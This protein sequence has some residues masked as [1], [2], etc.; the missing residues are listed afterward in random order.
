MKIEVVMPKMGESLQEGTITKWLKKEGEIVERDE[1]ILEIST[2]KV[3]TE[4]PSPNAGVL[5]KILVQE[6]ETVEVGTPIAIIETD[7]SAVAETNSEP[8]KP[9]EVKA[10]E[11]TPQPTPEVVPEAPQTAPASGNT[12]DVVMPK[13]GESLQEGTVIKWLKKVGEVV[14]RDEMILEISTDKVDTEVPSPVSGTIV[15]ILANE[16]DTVE[17][18]VVIARIS[19]GASSV[20]TPSTKEEAPKAETKPEPSP[21]AK[22]SAPEVVIPVSGGTTEI[23]SR[24]GD[25]FYSPLVRAMAKDSGV[26]LE[27]LQQIQGTGIQGRVTK[28][29][30]NKYIANRGTAKS[31]ATPATAQAS[32]TVKPATS[33]ASV[34]AAPKAPVIN[35][36][37]GDDVEIIPMDRIRQLI[38]DHMVY[39]KHTSAHVTSVAEVD[40]TNLVNFRNKYKDKFE[41][42]E[43]FK[44]TYTPF[45]VQA[46][47]D[48]IR[49]FPM[50]NVSVDGKNIIR[51]KRINLGVATA[52]PDGNLIVP[53]IKNA[54]VLNI[55]GLARSVYDLATRARNKKLVPDEIQGG[56][57][58]LTNVGTFGTL[59][60]TPVINQ[61]QCGIF[62]V[63]AIKKRAVVKEVEGND[64]ILVRH[65]MY[66]SITYDH[67]VIDGML[68]GQ[69]LAAFVKALENMNENTITL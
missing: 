10:P 30:L 49:Q 34:P 9:Q 13:M 33:T 47:V 1:M 55:T 50:V 63:G 21:S 22:T 27:E 35:L 20:A 14:E 4:V 24:M 65:M 29:D 57:F 62:G 41:K 38:S 39:S 60:G 19:T 46:A 56:T 6:Q 66:C 53:V 43:G 28:E 11:P 32:A 67:R 45:F 31:Q 42:Q 58:T 25:N 16:G 59:F 12:I 8:P 44:L 36:P 2:D 37:S 61:P 26:T 17:V 15:E 48:A 52:L 51:H 68:A 64:L 18:G 7:A 5:S 40:V 69:T 23:P 3:D 54:E